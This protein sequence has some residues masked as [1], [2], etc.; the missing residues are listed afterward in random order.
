MILSYM[1]HRAMRYERIVLWNIVHSP[2]QMNEVARIALDDTEA[3]KMNSAHYEEVLDPMAAALISPLANLRRQWLRLVAWISFVGFNIIMSLIVYGIILLMLLIMCLYVS[4]ELLSVAA[5]LNAF[6]FRPHWPFEPTSVI[7]ILILGL[8][9]LLLFLAW[10]NAAWIVLI[11]LLAIIGVPAILVF[12]CIVLA[13]RTV[14]F[15]PVRVVLRAIY[16]VA[17]QMREKHRDRIFV[18]EMAA[19]IK[20]KEAP[21]EERVAEYRSRL[22]LFSAAGDLSSRLYTIQRNFGRGIV[23]GGSTGVD[24]GSEWEN[25]ITRYGFTD[26]DICTYYLMV[27][28]QLAP[29]KFVTS[30]AW[31]LHREVERVVDAYS[32]PP[33]DALL[34]A[35]E[36]AASLSH[37]ERRKLAAQILARNASIAPI[38]TKIRR[39]EKRWGRELA[40]LITGEA[41]LYHSNVNI[42]ELRKAAIKYFGEPESKNTPFQEPP[43]GRGARDSRVITYL[44][45]LLGRAADA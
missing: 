26:L 29:F 8:S 1:L 37:S 42:F 14:A 4:K 18:N 43:P 7:D 31:S 24:L 9:T 45:G 13:W 19:Y 30:D 20:R 28:A 16:D 2:E 12:R 35:I 39:F 3:Y 32:D 17:S 23:E 34:A 41:V 6:G 22:K 25:L 36:K 11:A 33:D 44:L 21:D 40:K 27:F 10:S 15:A 38:G 5:S